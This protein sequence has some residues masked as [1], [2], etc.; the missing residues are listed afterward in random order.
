M[1]IIDLVMLTESL[2]HSFKIFKIYLN[3]IIA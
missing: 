3:K 2:F 1:L